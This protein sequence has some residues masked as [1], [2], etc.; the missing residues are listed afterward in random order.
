MNKEIAYSA[1]AGD[2]T[3]LA[4]IHTHAIGFN[5]NGLLWMLNYVQKFNAS[6]SEKK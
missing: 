6:N 1:D 3:M 2:I 4:H 5:P